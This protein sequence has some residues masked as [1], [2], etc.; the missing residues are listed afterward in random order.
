MRLGQ[1]TNCAAVVARVDGRGVN[2]RRR[3]QLKGSII[4]HSI[5][6]CALA[7]RQHRVHCIG[8]DSHLVT[9]QAQAG[10]GAV[11]GDKLVCQESSAF[12]SSS[13]PCLHKTV[14]HEGCFH[15][16]DL[17]SK[18]PTCKSEKSI[19]QVPCV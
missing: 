10:K 5:S 12:L 6:K 18:S 19:M 8:T 11:C 4:A 15:N 16:Y 1:H 17:I 3:P 7:A 13:Y 9:D 14:L 2:D